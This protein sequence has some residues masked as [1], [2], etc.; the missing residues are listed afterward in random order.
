MSGGLLTG[1]GVALAAGFCVGKRFLAY[2]KPQF[3]QRPNAGSISIPHLG[4]TY[5][6]WLLKGS[7]DCT[8]SSL[9]VYLRYGTLLFPVMQAACF[10]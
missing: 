7:L 9:R 4:H 5:P 3:G 2:N 8:H 6:G 10:S 1:A